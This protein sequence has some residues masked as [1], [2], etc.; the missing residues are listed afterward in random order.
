M[1]AVPASDSDILRMRGNVRIP[2]VSHRPPQIKNLAPRRIEGP[3]RVVAFNAQSGSRFDGILRCLRRAPLAQ[4]SL[5]LLCEVDLQTRRANG[6]RVA[7]DLADALGMS[8][9][10]QPQYAFRYPGGG[11]GGSVGVAI[12]CATPIIEASTIIVPEPAS[13]LRPRPLALK[14]LRLVGAPLALRARIRLG[15]KPIEA[16]VAHLQRRCPPAGRALQIKAITKALGERT[17][18]GGDFN[19]TTT[20]VSRTETKLS[21]LRKMIRSPARFRYPQPYE[22]LFDYL[23]KAGFSTRE[24]N[25]PGR[26]TFTF[27]RFVPPPF[28]PRLDWIALR[29]IETVS[30]SALVVPARSSVFSA[31]VSDHDFIAVDIRP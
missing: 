4:A 10:Y 2:E 12:L 18:L 5:V 27:S 19:T 30:G 24:A 7:F 20:E 29:G 17:V 26:G 9:A 21:V 1:S 6:R 16:A 15:P 3:I 14:S 8:C 22:P 28:R 31:R 11:E 13:A 23:S 25:A